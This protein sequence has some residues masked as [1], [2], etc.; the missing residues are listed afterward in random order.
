MIT[1]SAPLP[2]RHVISDDCQNLKSAMQYPVKDNKMPA[3]YPLFNTY[4]EF[5][6]HTSDEPDPCL[7]L[8]MNYL[9]NFDAYLK[10]MDGFEAVRGFLRSYSNVGMSG[11]LDR[12]IESGC[13]VSPD[14]GFR[15]ASLLWLRETS[16]H[17]S[18]RTLRMDD[19]TRLVRKSNA[20]TAYQ[21]FCAWRG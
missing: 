1:S 6:N 17:H 20:E 2:D 11:R 19:V 14:S 12:L 10:P 15:K 7:P 5:V 18:A 13:V 9:A 3:P 16:M 21:R 8:V 4:K